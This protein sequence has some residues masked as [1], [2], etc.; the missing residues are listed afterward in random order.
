MA[1][2][3]RR[4]TN[5]MWVMQ[6]QR[7]ADVGVMIYVIPTSAHNHGHTQTV[8]DWMRSGE[9]LS[10][11]MARELWKMNASHLRFYI[12]QIKRRGWQVEQETH[13]LIGLPYIET[14]TQYRLTTWK[15]EGAHNEHRV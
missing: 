10:D 11:I 4:Y 3:R 2:S 9:W 15:P 8:F 1:D 14:F 13:S 12:R 6:R 7:G 5:Q